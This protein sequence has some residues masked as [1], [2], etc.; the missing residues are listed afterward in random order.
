MKN[1]GIE[2]IEQMFEASAHLSFSRFEPFLNI[3]KGVSYRADILEDF[4]PKHITVKIEG[5]NYKYLF[6]LNELPNVINKIAWASKDKIS[7]PIHKNCKYN[8]NSSENYR[9]I[10]PMAK[11]SNTVDEFIDIRQFDYLRENISDEFLKFVN[12]Q[13]W[14]YKNGE[15]S[16]EDWNELIY[17]FGNIWRDKQLVY[18][19]K[20]VMTFLRK[21]RE[22]ARKIKL[23]HYEHLDPSFIDFLNAYNL[24]K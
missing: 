19:P 3:E 17:K 16:G 5:K 21:Q 7:D 11:V 1:E 12:R 6:P 24:E 14:I 13:I 9:P 8:P 22:K 23:G 4:Q 20:A 10:Y 2:I 15:K 18:G